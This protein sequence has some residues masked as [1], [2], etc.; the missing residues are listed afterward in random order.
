MNEIQITARTVRIVKRIMRPVAEEGL[1]PL[2]EYNEIIS[3]LTSLAEHGTVKPAITPRLVDQ[4]E[5]A[6]MLGVSYS[7]FK[8]LE[9]E[10]AFSFKRK[11]VG[12]SVRYRNTDIVAFILSEKE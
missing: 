10:G 12:S 4:H 7:N 3:Q 1:I 8:K 5:A 9:G 2:P 11:M 6:E